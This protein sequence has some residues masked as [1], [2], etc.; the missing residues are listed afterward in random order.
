MDVRGATFYFFMFCYYFLVF[1]LFT[2]YEFWFVFCMECQHPNQELV[3]ELCFQDFFYC[4]DEDEVKR[5]AMHL[6]VDKDKYQKV[7]KTKH[8][9]M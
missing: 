9:W 3:M 7:K 1:L 2:T 8:S 4:E 5:L 6:V